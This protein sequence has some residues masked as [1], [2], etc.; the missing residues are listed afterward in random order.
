MK[1]SDV[2]AYVLL[3]GLFIYL[4]IV[5]DGSDRVFPVVMLSLLVGTFVVRWRDEGKPR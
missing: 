5:E 2:A 1:R 3:S 4:A